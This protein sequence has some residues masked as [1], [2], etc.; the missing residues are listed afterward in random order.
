M[1]TCYTLLGVL[2]MVLF[3]LV[4][5]PAEAQSPDSLGYAAAEGDA[6]VMLFGPRYL[7][8]LV[9][10]VVLALAF[11]LLLTNLSVAAGLDISRLHD[12]DD[13][14]ATSNKG[15]ASSTSVVSRVTGAFGMWSL[16][17][18]TVA[19]FFASLLAGTLG[20]LA[21]P[22]AGAVFGLAIWAV[23]YLLLVRFEVNVATSIVG[24]L[25]STTTTALSAATHQTRSL[26][27]GAGHLV[28]AGTGGNTA[29][30]LRNR[31][32]NSD[33]ASHQREQIRRMAYQL[34]AQTGLTPEA[35]RELLYE[36]V[37]DPREGVD[38]LFARLQLLDRTRVKQIMLEHEDLS[39]EDAELILGHYD[40]AREHI[41]TN[42]E[43]VRAGIQQRIDTL[44]KEVAT[45]AEKTR[46]WV[47]QMAWWSF[48]V[49]VISGAASA[50]G[51][52]L[53]A[54]LNVPV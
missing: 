14:D 15:N 16:I 23:F 35:V 51:G 22:E 53:A 44:R 11:Q 45:Q 20:F 24:S 25:L 33:E 27:G 32:E 29:H 41:L 31:L 17:T 5:L 48:G 43:D 39:E 50:I 28:T 21:N 8:A 7:I 42:K 18:A 38:D 4:G 2:S 49:A 37:Q 6:R 26:L 34:R 13:K 46:Q 3:L 54:L 12:S 47:A 40:T 9:V 19:L 30:T 36:F 1:K 52:T 10:G